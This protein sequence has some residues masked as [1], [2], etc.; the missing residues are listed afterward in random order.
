MHELK[1]YRRA[2]CHYNEEWC[3]I[4]RGIY[5]SVQNWHAEFN[6]F[7]PKHSKIWKIYTLMC[8]FWPKYIMFELK[9]YR[10]FMF[11]GKLTCTSKNNIRNLANFHQ[12]TWKSQNWDFDAILLSK[13]GSFQ[14]T[15][16][17]NFQFLTPLPP[18]FVPVRFTCTPSQRT[19]PLVSYPSH[20]LSKKV[21]R[22]L[23]CLF[24]IKNWGVKREKRINFFVN[25]T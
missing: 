7:W 6:E 9:K 20:P 25:S 18:L 2:I 14:S 15:F 4:G 5:F 3:N 8:C 10:G 24:W 12:S 21:P 17:R 13:M 22:R 16:A 1:I 19:F 11:E 23:W